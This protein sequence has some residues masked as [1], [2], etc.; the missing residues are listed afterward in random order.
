M[1]EGLVPPI[2]YP[3]AHGFIEEE[4]KRLSRAP[5][6]GRIL[7]DR[8]RFNVYYSLNHDSTQHGLDQ[9]GCR[10]LQWLF[11]NFDPEGGNT[12]SARFS[13][14][15]VVIHA[16]DPRKAAALANALIL[17]RFLGAAE[18]QAIARILV[19][20]WNPFRG[21]PRLA[22]KEYEKRVLDFLHGEIFYPE[23]V[24]LFDIL[25]RNDL[26]AHRDLEPCC[27]TQIGFILPLLEWA[28]ECWPETPA[29]EAELKVKLRRSLGDE[30]KY[31]R[32]RPV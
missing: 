12:I 4:S 16:E 25:G 21:S 2:V 19:W 26:K 17:L 30:V 8:E 7:R 3:Y 10:L 6:P 5:D 24:S 28:D 1:L 13:E 15:P 20:P 11:R 22:A 14:I 18:D 29:A 31:L 27:L 32:R 23:D 9:Q